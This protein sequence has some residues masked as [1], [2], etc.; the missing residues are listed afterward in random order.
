MGSLSLLVMSKPASASNSFREEASRGAA[1]IL[2]LT[3]SLKAQGKRQVHAEVALL[4]GQIL[5]DAED[6]RFLGIYN[7]LKVKETNAIFLL[8]CDDHWTQRFPQQYMV[9]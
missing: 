2:M 7:R 1:V 8:S 6:A 4:K 3:S 5:K 9:T